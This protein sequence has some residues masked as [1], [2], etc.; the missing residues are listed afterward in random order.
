MK[1]NFF[2]LHIGDFLGGTMGLD[3]QEL[4]A[5]TSLLI[6]HYQAGVDGLLDDDVFLARVARVS[7]KVWKRIKMRVLAKFEQNQG[8]WI[9][10]RVVEELRKMHELST[11]NSE[12]SLKRWN[13]PKPTAKQRVSKPIANSQC[14]YEAKVI[15]LKQ[16]TFDKWLAMTDMDEFEFARWLDNEDKWLDSLPA[17]QKAKWFFIVESKLKKMRAA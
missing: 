13:T 8:H 5:Y 16:E 1:V 17:E 11:Q 9:H 12:K 14:I 4:G 2:S 10:E 7:T 6:A 3:A 15:R